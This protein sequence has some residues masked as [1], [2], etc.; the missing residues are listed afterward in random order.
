MYL[1]NIDKTSGVQSFT[2]CRILHLLVTL[3]TDGLA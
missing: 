2:D 3:E 1:H